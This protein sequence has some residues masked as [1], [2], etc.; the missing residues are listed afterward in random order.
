LEK[1]PATGN[2]P[3]AYPTANLRQALRQVDAMAP[4]VVMVD[5]VEKALAGASGP[6]GDSGVASRIFAGLLTW[7]NDHESDA[8]V[9]CTSNDVSRLPPE[10]ARSERCAPFHG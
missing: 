6:S 9:V 8:F 2:S 1:C 4:C 3:A 10:F 5:E 7:L